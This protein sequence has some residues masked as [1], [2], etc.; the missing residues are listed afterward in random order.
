MYN[1]RKEGNA[2]KT[3]VIAGKIVQISSIVCP[4]SKYRLII[5]FQFKDTM[6]YP[7]I[8]VIIDKIII[9]WSWKKIN[10]S[11]NEEFASWII[12]SPHIA[13]SNKR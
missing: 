12:I 6:I 13:I 11:I 9:V 5:L 10:C 7:T 2:I 3:S 8:I 1:N 4:S